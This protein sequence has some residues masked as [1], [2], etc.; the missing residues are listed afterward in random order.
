MT[1]SAS[2]ASRTKVRPYASDL[3]LLCRRH[4]KPVMDF[5]RRHQSA[6]EIEDLAQDVFEQL[7]KRS[8]ATAI[9]HPR[10]YLY[11]TAK[12]RI[13]E[14]DRQHR[15]LNRAL[16]A[17][18]PADDA[19]AFTPTE[20]LD[21]RDRLTDVFHA[22]IHLPQTQCL[23]FLM[24]RFD[25]LTARDIAQRLILPRS[26]VQEKITDATRICRMAESDE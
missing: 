15:A 4:R 24:A 9:N 21:A 20:I 8:Q 10:A 7:V 25:D 19:Q 13:M 6:L 5:I 3:A 11:A 14:T 16:A 17:L 23:A 22:I 1:S 2:G 26:R 18:D 12:Q